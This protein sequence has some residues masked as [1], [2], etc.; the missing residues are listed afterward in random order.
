MNIEPVRPDLGEIASRIGKLHK[1][2]LAL[3]RT[4]LRRAVEVGHLL[5][6]A[7]GLL[8][9][10]SWL[11]WLDT[12]TTVGK[13][14][15]QTYM[16]LYQNRDALDANARS[17]A[18]LTI[19]GAVLELRQPWWEKR[20]TTSVISLLSGDRAPEEAVHSITRNKPENASR[21]THKVINL[22]E[23]A[24][25]RRPNEAKDVGSMH[26]QDQLRHSQSNQRPG[27]SETLRELVD[28]WNRASQGDR[29]TFLD[30][31]T[32]TDDISF[33]EISARRV[34]RK[35]RNVELAPAK[36]ARKQNPVER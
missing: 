5:T 31:L 36:T 18:L 32:G 33:T 26:W 29:Q 1:E 13:R 35:N 22:A 20:G 8:P 34:E 30:A 27:S 24:P 28:C 4:T 7:K 10:G 25:N 21:E 3:E 9:H 19:S 14:Q 6:E 16:Q 15:A 11:D 12:H 2:V 23:F 17:N